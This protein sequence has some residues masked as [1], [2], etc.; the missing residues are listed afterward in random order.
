MFPADIYMA[1]HPI[2]A[3]ATSIAPVLRWGRSDAPSPVTCFV[4]AWILVVA[5]RFGSLRKALDMRSNCSGLDHRQM[6]CNSEVFGSQIQYPGNEN[7]L[8][9]VTRFQKNVRK[10]LRCFDAE[11][12]GRYRKEVALPDI[13]AR[14][15]VP[16]YTNVEGSIVGPMPDWDHLCPFQQSLADS[17][18]FQR[19]TQRGG[20]GIFSNGR[21]ATSLN[22]VYKPA[23]QCPETGTGIVLAGDE[24]DMAEIVQKNGIRRM[25]EM[26][27]DLS[28]IRQFK[29]AKRMN[30]LTGVV[31]Q[32]PVD[33]SSDDVL[34][35]SRIDQH[36]VF[37]KS[38]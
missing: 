12:L 24:N 4:E 3:A 2:E 32:I 27:G 30:G 10:V 1:T 25:P 22:R 8:G 15:I 17:C 33:G 6:V 23:R 31:A 19:F 5:A 9:V 7:P 26:D 36:M 21:A 14:H 37:Y 29:S 11:G 28:T 20:Y 38:V 34:L 16:C 35:H 18:L 13:G